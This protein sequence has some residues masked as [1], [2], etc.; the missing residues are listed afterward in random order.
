MKVSPEFQRHIELLEGF[1][2]RAYKDAAGLLTIGYGH[3]IKPAEARLKQATLSREEGLELLRK[4]V[5]WAEETVERY[6]TVPL[7][8]RQF[9][10]LVSF[11]FN[12][13]PTQFRQSTLLKVLN[14]GRCCAVPDELR[15]WNRANGRVVQGLVNRRNEEVALW[16]G[17]G[18][19]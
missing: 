19:A 11:V 9:D 14:Q 15:R 16:T 3:L 10:A 12:V 1:R 6:V 2:S 17:A 5:K 4:D 8:Q 13:G 18:V 7:L